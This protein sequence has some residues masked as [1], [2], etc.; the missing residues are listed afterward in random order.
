[1]WGVASNI[2]AMRRNI[3]NRISCNRH[4]AIKKSH[5]GFSRKNDFGVAIPKFG[6][7]ISILG[8]LI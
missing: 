8:L 5:P 4:S 7:H 3:G 6:I 1:M 2:K